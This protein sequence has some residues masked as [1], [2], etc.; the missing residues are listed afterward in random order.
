MPSQS[1][2]TLWLCLGNTGS[3]H[4]LICAVAN[5]V[6]TVSR[7]SSLSMNDGDRMPHARLIWIQ[8]LLQNWPG[9]R[10]QEE[11][12]DSPLS[13]GPK[14]KITSLWLCVC[15][16]RL[17]YGST[18]GCSRNTCLLSTYWSGS[19][20]KA[21]KQSTAMSKGGNEVFF[22]NIRFFPLW[23]SAHSQPKAESLSKMRN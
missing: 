2:N 14:W 6:A 20:M 11:W 16:W 7:S 9:C 8:L 17:G 19:L 3:T 13:S 22:P 10:M 5:P 18:Q 15:V 1:A 12:M 4:S 23:K 21:N